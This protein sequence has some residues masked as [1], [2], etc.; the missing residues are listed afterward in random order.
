MKMKTLYIVTSDLVWHGAALLSRH[1]AAL[2]LGLV[3]ALG[4]HHLYTHCTVL[5]CT[6]LCL[7]HL[8]LLGLAHLPAG[9]V[10]VVAARAGDRHPH[11]T[12]LN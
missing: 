9:V 3:P 6:A 8:A 4:L 7:H 12:P 5:Y 1:L 11:L 10:R 2:L